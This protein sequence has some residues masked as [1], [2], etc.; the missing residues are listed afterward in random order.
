MS[1]A[2]F[3]LYRAFHPKAADYTFFSSAQAYSPG[4]ITN[5]A[6]RQVLVNLRKSKSSILS[7][8]NAETRNKLYKKNLKNQN[9]W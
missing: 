4:L 1:W 6:T 7:D 9:T 5:W 8:Q 2:F 3:D